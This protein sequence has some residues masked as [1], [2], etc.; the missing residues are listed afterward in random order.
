MNLHEYQA[1]TFLKKYK[2]D[3]PKGIL[4]QKNEPDT[5]KKAYTDL[6]NSIVVVKAQIH[7]GGRGQGKVYNGED[8][9][10]SKLIQNGGVKVTSSLEETSKCIDN[11]LNNYLL[12]EQTAGSAKQVL[13]VYLEEGITIKKEVYFSILLDRALRKPTIIASSVGGMDIETIAKKN[14]DSILRLPIDPS[15]GLQN[16]QLRALCYHFGFP[17]AT[18]P[19]AFTFFTN[20]WEFYLQEDAS[21]V[22]VNPLVL[23]EE[24]QVIA[25]DCKCSIDDNALYRHTST[26]KLL[27]TTEVDPLEVEA[28]KHS[29]NYV[30][31]DG[32]VGCMVN[33]AG[34]AM[35]TM[36]M[37]QI[38][39]AKPANF[40]DVG[41]GANAETV[42]QG[43]K[44]ILDDPN[45]KAI[46]VNIFGGIVQCDRVAQ[47]IV[48]AARKVKIT[49]PLIVR[50]AG[51]NADKAKVIL[52]EANLSVIVAENFQDGATKISRLIKEISKKGK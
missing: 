33:G 2:V 51:T 41:G 28:D 44:I 8:P 12:T 6:G 11:I 13:K 48:D 34:L 47:G 49:L 26:Q 1:K 45:I 4:I 52:E 14:P 20:L 29:L 50:L 7:A 16:W 18:L 36:D 19:S 40:L 10:K 32:N 38:A 5:I 21:L 3:V 42:A 9:K 27:D 37:I 22:E 25:L 39:G 24:G 30:K 23:T 17:K 46:F 31:L 15:L 43:F 35:A